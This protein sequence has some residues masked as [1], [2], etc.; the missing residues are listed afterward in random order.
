M[1]TS[2]VIRVQRRGHEG[3]NRWQNLH[4]EDFKV[5]LYALGN[6]SDFRNCGNKDVYDEQT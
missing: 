5:C 4:R 6:I 2:A 1:K 3:W